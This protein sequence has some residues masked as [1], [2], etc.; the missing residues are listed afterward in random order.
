MCI[1]DRDLVKAQEA[2]C[3]IV[4]ITFLMNDDEKSLDLL[5]KAAK[6][7]ARIYFRGR[8]KRLYVNTQGVLSCARKASDRATYS[9]DFIV[10]PQLFQPETIR[11]AHNDTGHQGMHKLTL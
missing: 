2:D 7:R 10:L 5:P 6:K 3:L 11:L 1:R 4:A 9:D 8:K